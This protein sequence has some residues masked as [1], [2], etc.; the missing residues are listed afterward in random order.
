M[1]DIVDISSTVSGLDSRGKRLLRILVPVACV[2][3]MMGSILGIAL[4]SYSENRKDALALSDAL[5]SS[6][7]RQIA[8][9]VRNFLSPATALVD[10]VQ[11]TLENPAYRDSRRTLVEPLAMQMLEAYPQLAMFNLGDPAGGFM[12]LKKMPDS[13]IDTK[14]I[15]RERNGARVEWVRR[16]P[17]GRVLKT[18][19]TE[20]DGYDPRERPWYK[21][22][23]ESAGVYWTGIYIFFTDRKPGITASKALRNDSGELLGVVSLDIELENLSRF[24]ATLRIGRSGRAMIVDST[25]HLVAFPEPGRMIVKKENK[26]V[27]VRL[28]ELNDPVLTRAFSRFRVERAGH[29]EL[30][31]N[32]EAYINTAS[33]L[34]SVVGR[35]WS[36]LIVAPVEDFV[37]FVSRNYRKV[38][39]VSA[40]VFLLA[41]AMAGLLIWQGL[42]ADRNAR[43][44][45]SRRRAMETQ[46]RA[47][48]ELAAKPALFDPQDLSGMQDLTR[49]VADSSGVRRVSVWQWLEGGQRLDCAD[50]Y[51]RES[52]G[53]TRGMVLHR[54]SLPQA[55][56]A[57][58]QEGGL[59]VGDTSRDPR[60][61]ELHRAYLEPMGCNGL[62]SSP[63]RSDRESWGVL[64]LEREE[65]GQ[66]WGAEEMS[67]ARAVSGLLALRLRADRGRAASGPEIGS[68]SPAARAATGGAAATH[69][70]QGKGPATEMR[71]TAILDVRARAFRKQTEDR[72]PTGQAL[73]A[74][75]FAD[76][77]VLVL[78]LA[79]PVALAEQPRDEAQGA[80]VQRLIDRLEE[81]AAAS[82]VEYMKLMGE[83][84]V[85]A[86]GLGGDGG[87]GHADAMAMLALEFQDACLHIFP[88]SAGSPDFRIGVDTGG[89][90]GSLVGH[91]PGIY[92]LW[93]DAI[94]TAASMAAS[95]PSGG[96]HVSESTYQRI[97]DRFLFKLRGRFYLPRVGEMSTF[98]LTGPL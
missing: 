44:L 49:I 82:G 12:M 42:R 37:G 67:F 13:S 81:L 7:D 53:H 76:V 21:G 4:Y 45:L 57:L 75:V 20:W 59:S 70:G 92:N 5:L 98:V 6:L 95:G 47:F 10:V 43:W 30:H 26:V 58:L 25:G 61:A 71:E 78:Q 54:E 39:L 3:L 29:R 38:L 64:W 96:V 35:D 74:D 40:G 55:F 24:L 19:R 46:S 52:G 79:D 68:V 1:Q 28:D 17:E 87:S 86:A 56:E 80:A 41:S 9:E 77:T 60:L 8:I 72:A 63:I 91:E 88:D 16:T 93:G 31:V 2:V 85:C 34:Q 36:I 18:E 84:L 14:I 27:P 83:Q 32:G 62:L 51:D 97:R 65:A 73:A 50:C 94:G 22:A 11:S 48:S 66:G 33:S 23:S 69:A 15:R 90:I 89:A